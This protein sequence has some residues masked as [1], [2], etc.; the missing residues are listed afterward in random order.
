MNASNDLVRKLENTLNPLQKG[1][2]KLEPESPVPS[3]DEVGVETAMKYRYDNDS[4]D[5]DDEADSM[6]GIE[7]IRSSSG[8]SCDSENSIEMTF[9]Q[10]EQLEELKNN[11]ESQQRHSFNLM[12]DINELSN[13]I[14]DLITCQICY[15]QFQAAGERIPCKLKCPH[16]MC[17]K[18]AEGWITT[19]VSAH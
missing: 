17:K 10:I 19:R 14:N 8:E 5:G 18:C 7:N 2:E 9:I 13:T 12:E 1:P 15:E 11:I 6:H 16:I 3:D 4:F